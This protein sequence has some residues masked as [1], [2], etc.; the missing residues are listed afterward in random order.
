MLLRIEKV[1]FNE[2][3]STE[4]YGSKVRASDATARRHMPDMICS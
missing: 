1:A 2:E 4:Q 3:W